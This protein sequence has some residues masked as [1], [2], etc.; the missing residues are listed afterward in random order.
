MA[1]KMPP[2]E[3]EL[4]Y[5][6]D[7]E[8][9]SALIRATRSKVVGTVRQTNIYFDDSTLRLRKQKIGLRIRIQ[10][11]N[12]ATLTLKEPSGIR[13]KKV[14]KL[15]VRHEW[16]SPIPLKTAR[17]LIKRKTA[18]HALSHTPIKM[19]KKRFSKEELKR[20]GPLGSVKTIRTFALAQKGVLLEID[21]FKMFNKKF[22][23]LEVETQSPEI[24]DKVI[25]GL[26]KDLH[27]PYR[28]ITKSKLGRFLDLWKKSKD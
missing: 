22:Y 1:T 20:I 2:L 27:I 28:P 9:Y 19:L 21:K 4:K 8:G 25:K 17:N 6:L 7:K 16:E 23:E 15:K 12:K 13:S 18:I 3:K 24:A 10:D 26:L 11:G 14:P 5:F